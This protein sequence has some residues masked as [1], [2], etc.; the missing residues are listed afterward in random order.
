M[1]KKL[2]NARLY[3]E[4]LDLIRSKYNKLEEE[5]KLEKSSIPKVV[6]TILRSDKVQ[7][8]WSGS[9]LKRRSLL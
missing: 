9:T 7:T 4:T 8:L 2:R 3:Q 6:D 5:L 1:T